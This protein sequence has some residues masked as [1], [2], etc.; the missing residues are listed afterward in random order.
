M[1][2]PDG[3]EKQVSW[4][5][6]CCVPL[7]KRIISRVRIEIY[8]HLYI[9]ASICI[10]PTPRTAGLASSV[11]SSSRGQVSRT[12]RWS[13]QRL[14][15]TPPGT[16]GAAWCGGNTG[17]VRTRAVGSEVSLYFTAGSLGLAQGQSKEVAWCMMNGLRGRR[18]SWGTFG[19]MHAGWRGFPRLQLCWVLTLSKLDL[20]IGLP[21][22]N[23]CS[24]YLC[25]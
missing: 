10:E 21:F 12:R 14:D 2:S 9:N 3:T 15:R 19:G 18:P 1:G 20:Y 24:V 8:I 16:G 5:A 23:S 7:Y 25:S 22:I 6:A 11:R 17:S 4:Q 13:C